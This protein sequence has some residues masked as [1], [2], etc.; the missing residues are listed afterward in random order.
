MPLTLPQAAE[1]LVTNGY[2]KADP[3]PVASMVDGS[4]RMVTA[5]PGQRYWSLHDYPEEGVSFISVNP[6]PE[7]IEGAELHTS[8]SECWLSLKV[9]S[10]TVTEAWLG[11]SWSGCPMAQAKEPPVTG[12]EI[13]VLLNLTKRLLRDVALALEAN[14]DI[15]QAIDALLASDPEAIE[16]L[17]PVK[18]EQQ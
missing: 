14:K 16:L 12:A 2:T 10:G 11:E 3:K 17:D 6:G 15:S 8:Y 1:W 13:G 9:E 7:Q 18:E 4:T 5:P